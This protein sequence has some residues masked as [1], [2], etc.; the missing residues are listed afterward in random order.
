MIKKIR[1]HH[2]HPGGRVFSWLSLIM[3]VGTAM[4]IP[5]F[6]GFV[7]DILGSD[8]GVSV[9]YSIMALVMLGG[10]L[11]ST[12]I[13]E[14]IDRTKITKAS[15]II[16]AIVLIGFIFTTRVYELSLFQGIFVI[17]KLFSIMAVSLFVRD[18]T[19]IKD[20]GVEEG[21]FYR[22]NNIGF[23]I[24]L[25]AGGFLAS[26]FGYEIVF[27]IS[28]IVMFIGFLYF[29]HLH[30]V[31]QNPA[32]V[33]ENKTALPNVI[34]H[35]KK[36]FSS[37]NRKK[38]YLVT[39]SLMIWRGFK[40]LY[41]PLY[42]LES[43]YLESMSGLILALSI[44]PFIFLE[45]WVG[46][47]AEKKGIRIPIAGGF[48]LIAI[49]LLFVYLSPYILLNFAVLIVANIGAAF[50]EP[51]QEYYLFKHTPKKEEDELYGVYM[52]ADPVAYFLAPATG[53][54]IL[55]FLPFNY[56]FLLFAII[57]LVFGGYF[58]VALPER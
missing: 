47:Y 32:I 42:I 15:F 50:I 43:G 39:L 37:V 2:E 22:F 36:F 49:C 31:V 44:V 7:K 18:Y 58:W 30:I 46:E 3:G 40:T 48:F 19:K 35:L 13:L 6:P 56:L 5:I 45:V 10:G 53:A 51:L 24:G 38:A 8:G 4:L 23:L 28:A 12:V 57:W 21:V 55:F 9:F 29:N 11:A 14:K 52:T 33:Q 17:M 20:L 25:L 41:I 27:F 54:V 34:D 26:K 1:T 16:S